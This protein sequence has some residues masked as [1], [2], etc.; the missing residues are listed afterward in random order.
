MLPSEFGLLKWMNLLYISQVFNW[1]VSSG[2]YDEID[3][4]KCDSGYNGLLQ[5]MDTM[6]MLR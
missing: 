6:G 3:A 5:E 1:Y 4:S 2:N